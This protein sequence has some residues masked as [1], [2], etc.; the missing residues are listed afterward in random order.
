MAS[1]A[2]ERAARSLH[3]S[4]KPGSPRRC[5]SL[6]CP[7]LLV[8]S[9]VRPAGAGGRRW[10]HVDEPRPGRYRGKVKTTVNGKKIPSCSHYVSTPEEAA[11][12]ADK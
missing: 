9:D 1:A 7:F 8:L 12:L 10:I 6:P 4:G 2:G 5:L 3:G 11:A